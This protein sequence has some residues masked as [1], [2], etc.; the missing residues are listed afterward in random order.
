MG[1]RFTSFTS[2]R[3]KSIRDK[4]QLRNGAVADLSAR[5]REVGAGVVRVLERIA[6]PAMPERYLGGGGTGDRGW[7]ES[8][9]VGGR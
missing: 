1:F 8:G 5:A 2:T 9:R 7:E 6:D 3:T 4:L